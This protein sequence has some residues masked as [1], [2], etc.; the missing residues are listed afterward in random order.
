MTKLS[1]KLAKTFV[2]RH[3]KKYSFADFDYAHRPL[4]FVSPLDETPNGDE[5]P[6]SCAR[7]FDQQEAAA[8]AAR[9][10]RVYNDPP[11][12]DDLRVDCASIHRRNYFQTKTL[13]RKFASAA[14]TREC[15]CL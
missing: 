8:Y 15:A 6:L 12:L 3:Y 7:L 10:R 5:P 11:W 13:Y 9:G 14:P 1:L 4:R 2:E